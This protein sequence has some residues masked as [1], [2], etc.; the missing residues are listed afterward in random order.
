MSPT[1]RTVKSKCEIEY[2]METE[3]LKGRF[4]TTETQELVWGA[5][6]SQI[7][8]CLRIKINNDRKS[9]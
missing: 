7:W 4:K 6:T 2:T 8:D 5:P 9:F 1:K 3:P